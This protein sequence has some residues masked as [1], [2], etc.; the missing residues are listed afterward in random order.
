MGLWRHGER[1]AGNAEAERVEAECDGVGESGFAGA[2]GNR[3]G[4]EHISEIQALTRRLGRSAT[5][6]EGMGR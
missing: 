4:R 6:E 1:G 2:A 3:R 5:V